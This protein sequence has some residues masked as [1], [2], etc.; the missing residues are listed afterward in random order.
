MSLKKEKEGQK[1]NSKEENYQ[2][3]NSQKENQ[4]EIISPACRRKPQT[5]SLPLTGNRK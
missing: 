5:T 4:E 2:E 1:E 3:K